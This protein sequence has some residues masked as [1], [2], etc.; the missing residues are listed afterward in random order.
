MAKQNN[1]KT[2]LT[3]GEDHTVVTGGDEDSERVS[4]D[5]L[6][7]DGNEKSIEFKQKW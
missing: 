1:L 5:S 3:D 4:R 7:K 2:L 6:L